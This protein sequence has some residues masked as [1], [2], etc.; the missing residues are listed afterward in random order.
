MASLRLGVAFVL[1]CWPADPAWAVGPT[2]RIV[3]TA[4]SLSAPVEVTD[5][6][7][8]GAFLVWAGPGVRVNGQERLQGFIIDWPA[9]VVTQR[10][11]G[12][13]RYEVSF[14]VK[15]ANRSLASQPEE[16]AYVVWYETDS[17]SGRGYVYLPGKGDDGYTLNTRSIVRGREGHWYFATSAWH[18]VATVWIRRGR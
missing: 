15:H 16:L 14:Y 2:T 18:E 9:G 1:F 8:M 6:E 4:P 17:S 7:Q 13:P 3:I 5:A 11:A 12:L 10:P